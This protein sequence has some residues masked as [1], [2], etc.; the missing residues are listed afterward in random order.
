LKSTAADLPDPCARATALARFRLKVCLMYH[1]LH[2]GIDLLARALALGG[3]AVLLAVILLTCVSI[4]GRALMPLGLGAGPIRGIYDYT[5]IGMAA[6]IFAFLPIAQLREAHA[7]VDLF[8]TA[9]PRLMSQSLDLLFNCAMFAVAYVGTWRLYLGMHD[10]LRFGETT[11][12]AQIPVWQGYAVGLAGACG[13]VAVAGFCVLRSI[14][15]LA[16]IAD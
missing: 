8:Q 15:R 4:M 5:E 16:G 6:A 7:R 14:R 2:R 3:G 12:I 10:K 13:F 1:H 11:L 9:M